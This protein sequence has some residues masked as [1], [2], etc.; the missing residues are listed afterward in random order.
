MLAGCLA[1]AILFA[2]LDVALGLRAF[3]L[4]FLSPGALWGNGLLVLLA[5]TDIALCGCAVAR[6]LLLGWV[7]AQALRRLAVGPAPGVALLSVLWLL[8]AGDVSLVPDCST[9]KLCLW[10][11]LWIVAGIGYGVA[12]AAV[13]VA[14]GLWIARAPRRRWLACFAAAA[15]A[16]AVALVCLAAGGEM[17]PTLVVARQMVAGEARSM[18]A[19]ADYI[20]SACWAFTLAAVA[21]CAIAGACLG[22]ALGCLTPGLRRARKGWL[23]GAAAVLLAGGGAATLALAPRR[24]VSTA[25]PAASSVLLITVDALRSDQLSCYGA[26]TDTPNIDALAEKGVRFAQ[27]CSTAPWTRPSVASIHLGVYPSTHGI[28]ELGIG[29]EGGQVHTFPDALTTLAECFQDEGYCTQAFVSNVQLHETF[30]FSRGFD[31]YVRYENVGP[32]VAWISPGEAMRPERLLRRHA[33]RILRGEVLARR[34]PADAA[35]RGRRPCLLAS[36]DA[37]A[38]AAAIRWLRRVRGPFM[39][40]VHYM[41]VHE[42]GTFQCKDPEPVL[43]RDAEAGLRGAAVVAMGGPVEDD[44]FDRPM[45]VGQN[46]AIAPKWPAPQALH[47]PV[48]QGIDMGHYLARYRHNITYVDRL[49]GCLLA[50]LDTAGL[51]Y[52]TH[53]VFTS[54]HGEEFGEHDGAWH[55]RTQ[56]QEVT[57]VPLIVRS[58]RLARRSGRRVAGGVGLTSLAPTLCELAQLP[59]PAYTASPSLLELARGEAAGESQFVFSEFTDSPATE[60]K[61]MHW[62]M[63]KLVSASR[64][65]RAELY[66]L[67][68]DP[69]ERY[70]LAAAFPARLGELQQ[71]LRHWLVHQ[72]LLASRVREGVAQGRTTID[73]SMSEMLRSLGYLK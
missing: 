73:G 10:S 3:G 48:A 72:R 36:A 60:R 9:A 70:D 20:P 56:Y 68:V 28:G 25:D 16:L 1:G 39:L 51:G 4:R 44:P 45:H 47:D 41:A 53:V 31:G 54:D 65:R 13:L 67:A 40:W 63:L 71:H 42:Y 12:A 15:A 50:A 2:G 7:T 23:A 24:P 35:L 64:D 58:P 14:A 52:S 37:F 27:A 55:G 22:Q 5:Y 43:I 57:R 18:W 62:A 61:A 26:D 21:G 30:G 34:S 32:R 69:D 8:A 11:G 17:G 46:D 6:G 19:E 29:A 59:A 33:D 38:T 66:D 49:V